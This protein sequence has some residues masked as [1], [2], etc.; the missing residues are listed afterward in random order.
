MKKVSLSYISSR[1]G[2]TEVG[3]RRQG[4]LNLSGTGGSQRKD[5]ICKGDLEGV[6]YVGKGKTNTIDDVWAQECRS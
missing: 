1:G 6:R 5:W 4:Q 3:R 2:I